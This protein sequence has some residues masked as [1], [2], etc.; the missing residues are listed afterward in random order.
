[1]FRR[2]PEAVAPLSV[3]PLGSR[4]FADAA[5]VTADSECPLTAQD[6]ARFYADKT[7]TVHLAL[8]GR[9]AVGMMLHRRVSGGL[10]LVR[11]HVRAD[12][13]RRGVGRAMLGLLASI[14]AQTNR[15]CLSAVVC[16][17]ELTAQL[18]LAAC[19]W[20]YTETARGRFGDRA[21]YWFEN[22]LTTSEGV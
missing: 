13:R 10:R 11:I 7:R 21:G 15:R 18:F 4:Q 19:G 6:F 17:T 16:E 12:Y 5:A 14:G 20:E 22:Y 9:A 8:L 3:A 2:P 1:M